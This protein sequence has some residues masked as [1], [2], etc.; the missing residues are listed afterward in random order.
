MLLCTS[1]YLPFLL[2]WV[3]LPP[4]GELHFGPKLIGQL[5]LTRHLVL[6]LSPA[7]EILNI[8]HKTQIEISRESS[9]HTIW[10]SIGDGP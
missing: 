7:I 4:T 6:A 5:E 9:S 10:V 2:V 8:S 1:G 3:P